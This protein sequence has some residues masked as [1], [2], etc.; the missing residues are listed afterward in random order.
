MQQAWSLL[1]C[2]S[3]SVDESRALDILR[4]QVAQCLKDATLMVQVF[5][6]MM[7]RQA[8]QLNEEE[9]ILLFTTA[10]L[11]GRW[12]Q[13]V[14]LGDRLSAQLDLSDF[15]GAPMDYQILYELAK[16][17]QAKGNVPI[18]QLQWTNYMI[19]G[20]RIKL[21]T[22]ECSDQTILD[23]LEAEFS[24]NG[25]R[26]WKILSPVD[27]SR[28]VRCGALAQLRSFS[29]V[30]LALVGPMTDTRVY[31]QGYALLGDQQQQA[32][33]VSKQIETYDLSR[34]SFGELEGGD[35]SSDSSVPAGSLHWKGS[36]VM[37]QE[38]VLGEDGR[39]RVDAPRLNVTFELEM[40]IV[41]LK[42]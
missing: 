8:E 24:Q 16:V 17:E 41:P 7:Q 38:S 26:T 35:G 10:P 27:A 15:H 5:E 39:P 4:I 2:P 20:Q 14:Q 28:M 25:V 37:V 22:S 18:S 3:A 36:Y 12:Q 6:R 21:R 40:T 11:L 33:P 34:V 31:A 23:T 13:C 42:A 30:P 32:T 29:P 19:I 9:L 1:E